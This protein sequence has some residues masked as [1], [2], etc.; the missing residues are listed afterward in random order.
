[1]VLNADKCHSLIVGFN[2]PFVCFSVNDISKHENHT[3]VAKLKE[4]FK[5][6]GNFDFP[7]AI[8]K[9]KSKLINSKKATGTDKIPNKLV[10]LAANIIDCHICN[11]SDSEYFVKC[12]DL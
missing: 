2:E 3:G 4:A 12:L 7:K 5:S 9:D 1:M 11:N 10:K 6:F 8:P